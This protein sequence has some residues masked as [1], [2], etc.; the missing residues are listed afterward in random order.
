MPD[1]VHA[2]GNFNSRKDTFEDV[3]GCHAHTD[4]TDGQCT[5]RTLNLSR[6]VLFMIGTWRKAT[7]QN[8]KEI[9][10]LL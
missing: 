1:D 9:S 6:E 3:Y 7:V 10:K 4:G 2:L 8:S 5:K